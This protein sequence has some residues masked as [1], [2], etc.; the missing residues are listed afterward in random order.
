MLEITLS[1]IRLGCSFG[2]REEAIAAVAALLE[3]LGSVESGYAKS[4]LA[5]ESTA[6]TYLGNGVA[7]PHGRPQES[8]L[9][10]ET[11]VVLVQVPEGVEWKDG[12]T[13][14]LIFG[15]AAKGDEHIGLLGSLTSITSDEALA[16]KLAK[17]ESAEDIVSALRFSE[18]TAPDSA[19][20]V[21]FEGERTVVEFTNP[22]GF[23]LRPASQLA[24]ATECM[25]GRISL[26]VGGQEADARRPMSIV[27]L[28][29]KPGSQIEIRSDSLFAEDHLRQLS[30]LVELI[31]DE[32]QEQLEDLGTVAEWAPARLS[33]SQVLEGTMAA[34]GI[35]VGPLIVWRDKAIEERTRQRGDD[36]AEREALRLAVSR[37]VS[38]L[39][40]L[41]G[42]SQ[43]NQVQ[44]D[45]LNAH[46]ALLSD[47]VM[48]QDAVDRID[49]ETDSVQAWKQVIDERAN[50]LAQVQEA[51][52]AQRAVDLRD[53][54]SRV[55]RALVGAD[56]DRLTWVSEPSILVARDLE[57][58]E[59][60]QLSQSKVCG[61]CLAEG[62]PNA[63]SAIVAR[64]LGIPMIVAAKSILEEVR[65]G[66]PAILDASGNRLILDPSPEDQDS[67]CQTLKEIDHERKRAWSDRF[68]PA[69]TIDGCR[70]EIAANISRVAE[71]GDAIN[72][73][74]EGVGLVRTEFLFLD[75]EHAPSE[76][77][78]YE[79]YRGMVESLQGLPMILRTIDIGGDKPVNYLGLSERDLSFLGLRGIRIGLARP[80]ILTTQLRAVYRAAKHGPIKLLF[81]MIATSNDF[82][83]IRH[84]AEEVRQEVG[85]PQLELGVMIEVPS[86][87]VMARELA[88]VADFFSV[89]TNDLTQYALAVDR[90]HPLLAN[91]ADGLHPVVLRLIDQATK[92]A[93]AEGKGIGVC[94]GIAAD[95]MGAQIL[96]GI[97]VD[98]LSMPPTLI[99]SIK[100]TLRL[101]QM[102]VLR[103]NAQRA[104]EQEDAR[105]VRLLPLL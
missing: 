66:D 101:R 55:T 26:V 14:H 45:L 86:A 65:D 5:R 36:D 64:S 9:I 27:G 98:E 47:E 40:E 12:E 62:S 94:G 52:L 72:S 87:V 2:T 44:R 33:E 83:R 53:A 92:A 51:N 3:E 29:I 74:A 71:A 49:E 21:N 32:P 31:N 41:S 38:A 100:E 97:G 78:Q 6:N 84:V 24:Q 105:A 73:G 79:S 37:A 19:A 63:H 95:P 77:E 35:A 68:K 75:R 99:P 61:I 22:R 58:S 28:G 20:E 82:R 10:L 46:A 48:V 67:A 8:G 18:A 39:T 80:D 102:K 104:L 93:H 11:R 25:D 57:P 81:P 7:I 60:A 54:G 85:G 50:Q 89:G 96:A 42:D 23:H 70:I 13:A 91:R 43:M 34:P 4:M 59:A 76:D 30:R 15:I 88:R 69:K 16:R 56:E 1:D 103:E 90:T 17:T